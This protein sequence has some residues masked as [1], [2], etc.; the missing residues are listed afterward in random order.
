MSALAAIFHF[1]G[2][3]VVP[4]AIEDM[5][6]RMASRAPD[7]ASSWVEGNVGLG[8]GLLINTPEARHER[9]PLAV[10]D[11]RWHMVW[12]GRLDNRDE[13]RHEL[14]LQ[15]V[16]P[17]DDTD[18]ELVLQLFLLY[19][20]TTPQR[21]LGDFAFVVHDRSEQT[22]F[23][24]RDHV[25]ARPLHYVLTEHFIAIASTDDALIPLLP[26][27]ARPN[28]DRLIYAA[29]PLLDDFDWSEGWIDGIKTLLPGRFMKLGVGRR[30]RRQQYWAFT[31][32]P[33]DRTLA[34]ARPDDAVAAFAAV[35]E[36]ATRDRLRAPGAAAMLLSGGI[37]SACVAAS[38]HRQRGPVSSALA[39]SVISD[40]EIDCI[41]SA[42]IRSMLATLGWPAAQIQVPSFTG[43][44]NEAEVAALAWQRPH[45]VDNSILLVHALASLAARAGQRVLLHGVSGD[46]AFYGPDDHYLHVAR[47][48][49][50]R[51]AFTEMR[52]MRERHVYQLGRGVA[53]LLTRALWTHAVP[54]P[55]KR[56][57]PIRWR[58][59]RALAT[60]SGLDPKLLRE[61][62]IVERIRHAWAEADRFARLTPA[63]QHAVVLRPPGIVRGFE[64][65]DRVGGRVGVE[66]RDPLADVRVLEWLQ[67]A[68]LALRSAEGRT[69]WVGREYVRC[70]FGDTVAWRSDKSHLGWQLVA[71]ALH[72]ADESMTQDDGIDMTERG[73]EQRVALRWR[74]SLPS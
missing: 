25:G 56:L 38:I 18:P 15:G 17:R 22:L 69:K 60:A 21:L 2:R 27:G 33:E 26:D 24:A 64:G 40:P 51:A 11:G 48:H 12:D 44:M 73:Y 28:V 7:G 61:R 55:V 65:Y 70:V 23:C 37:D 74:Q 3:P 9:Q 14:H 58:S 72:H 47:Q 63:E 62:H 35:L 34:T 8:H 30:L 49:G 5:L 29:L 39:C 19:G 6:E 32:Q 66:M 68:P 13:V 31:V 42:A 43:A 4:T 53:S 1:D 10:L 52:L 20:E 71:A 50:W 45:P 36:R 46:L 41:E 67:R 59:A 16:T 57:R 54:L